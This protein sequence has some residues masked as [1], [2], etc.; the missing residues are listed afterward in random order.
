MCVNTHPC[1]IVLISAGDFFRRPIKV[2]PIVKLCTGVGFNLAVSCNHVIMPHNQR[3]L[4]L[5]GYL[6]P[7]SEIRFKERISSKARKRL[8]KQ[9]FKTVEASLARCSLRSRW[10][11]RN[12]PE[13][14]NPDGPISSSYFF[15]LTFFPC[16]VCCCFCS[17]SNI[18]CRECDR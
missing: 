3:E 15:P 10:D 17:V 2:R 12:F 14:T 1:E 16:I 7:P 18:V 8:K 6:V 4:I 9:I 11:G 5:R 13:E